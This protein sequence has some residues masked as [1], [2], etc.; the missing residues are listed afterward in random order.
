MHPVAGKRL[1]GIA[2]SLRDLVFLMRKDQI[3]ATTVDIDLL[4][5]VAQVHRRAFDVPTRSSL[6][7]RTIPAWFAWLGRL[8]EGE[9]AFVLLLLAARN[10]GARDGLGQA[11][12]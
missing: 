2:L 11:P 8:P 6:A 12:A 10:A 1:A 9:I 7:P 5:Q 4:A 3:V